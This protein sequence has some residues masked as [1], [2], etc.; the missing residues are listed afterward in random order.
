MDISSL[1]LS[2]QTA[3]I[4][5]KPIPWDGY[6]R[7]SLITSSELSLIKKFDRQPRAKQLQVFAHEEGVYAELFCTL[8]GKLVRVDTVQAVLV[9]MG[10]ML[11]E[12]PER[13]N[14]FLSLSEKNQDLPFGPL[15]KALSLPDEYIQLRAAQLL[16]VL[17]S[18]S[19]TP[20]PAATLKPLLNLLSSLLTGSSL[21]S[22]DIALQSLSLLLASA[23]VRQLVWSL[24]DSPAPVLSPLIKIIKSSASSP[25]MLYQ[26]GFCLWEVTFDREVSEGIDRKLSILPPLLHALQSSPKEKV[27]R[28][29]IATLRNLITLAPTINLP[30]ML[31]AKIL[32]ALVSLQGRKWGDDEVVEDLGICVDALKERA[33]GLSTWDEYTSELESGHLTWSPPHESEQFWK[34]NAVRLN[35]RDGELL[36]TLVNLLLNSSDALVLAVACADVGQYVKHCERGKKLVNALGAKTRVMELMTHE[37]PDVRYRALMSVQKLI[38]IS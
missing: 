21:N 19:K 31:A 38:S 16:T 35:E 22:K 8:L 9:G 14:L 24:E 33:E 25:Q 27:L 10:D 1:Y 15:V 7:A 32:P 2:D 34:E 36:K 13:F 20:T 6:Q 5:S 4:R 12:S 3:K 17:I 37:N 26:T 30:A 18:A 28:V 11:A 23:P 29:I